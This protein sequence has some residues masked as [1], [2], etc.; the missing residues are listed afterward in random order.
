MLPALAAGLLFL[1]PPSCAEWFMAGVFLPAG[2][3]ILYS[4]SMREVA[5]FQDLKRGAA[6]SVSI[7]FTEP[8]D[9]SSKPM[10][11]LLGIRGD[12]IIWKAYLPIKEFVNLNKTDVSCRNGKIIVRSECPGSTAYCKQIFSWDGTK[13]CLVGTESGDPSQAAVDQLIKISCS[14][15]R[16]DLSKWDSED[17][18]FRYPRNYITF[19]N[20]SKILQGGYDSAVKLDRAGKYMAACERLELCFDASQRFVSLQRGFDDRKSGP[21]KWIDAW[22]ADVIR[23][24]GHV[25]LPMLDYYSQILTKCHNPR[26]AKQVREIMAKEYVL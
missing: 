9:L 18:Q 24:P 12:R 26:M 15:S 5:D 10:A 7:L 2:E 17:H 23:L 6:D 8:D 22:Q 19:D 1:S 4:E 16:S 13:A 21:E 3:P 25:W 20:M 11:W 14:G